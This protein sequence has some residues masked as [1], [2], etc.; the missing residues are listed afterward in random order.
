MSST[1][2]FVGFDE[3]IQHSAHFCVNVLNTVNNFPSQGDFSEL[4]SGAGGAC[5]AAGS[6]IL[7][8]VEMKLQKKKK[9]KRSAAALWSETLNW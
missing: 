4:L 8:R 6:G 5:S 9:E 3:V 7:C 2:S 1:G